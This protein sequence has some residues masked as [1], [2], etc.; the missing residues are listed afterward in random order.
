MFGRSNAHGVHTKWGHREIRV[1]FYAMSFAFANCYIGPSVPLPPIAER[2][3]SKP[4]HTQSEHGQPKTHNLNRRNLIFL[5]TTNSHF[6]CPSAYIRPF[7]ST[8]SGDNGEKTRFKCKSK[9]SFCEPQIRN[10]R[11]QTPV[12]RVE[13]LIEHRSPL[14]SRGERKK[15][16]QE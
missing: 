3:P 1:S 8:N 12:T 14:D 6:V 2:Q 5:T 9:P 13:S 15:K 11:Q 16:I 10:N 4:P 7:E